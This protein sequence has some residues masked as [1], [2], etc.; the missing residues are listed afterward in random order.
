MK[1]FRFS[2]YFIICILMYSV[3][4]LAGMTGMP[5]VSDISETT[6]M[7][8]VQEITGMPGIT[9]EETKPAALDDQIAADLN[10]LI[11]YKT[12]ADKIYI[13]NNVLSYTSKQATSQ[14]SQINYC[15]ELKK[16]DKM[17][18]S[19]TLTKVQINQLLK[20]FKQAQTS[21]LMHAGSAKNISDI[22][23]YWEK[24]SKTVGVSRYQQALQRRREVPRTTRGR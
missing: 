19:Y 5:G 13:L 7:P 2:S 14:Q 18:K 4:N 9:T 15:D 23:Q 17:A 20:L 12:I 21:T 6:G 1:L 16:L 22:I 24:R 8:G 10:S 11:N 3:T